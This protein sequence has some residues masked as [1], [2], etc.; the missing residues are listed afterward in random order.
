MQNFCE[1]SVVTGA[2]A[3]FYAEYRYSYQSNGNGAY[4]DQELEKT[5]RDYAQLA[6]EGGF[7]PS[8]SGTCSQ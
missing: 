5:F 2:T 8:F 3:D 4:N 1:A 6:K 7:I